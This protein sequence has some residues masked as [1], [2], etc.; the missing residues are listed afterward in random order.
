V[1]VGAPCNTCDPDARFANIQRMSKR[2]TLAGQPPFVKGHFPDPKET[3]EQHKSG[4]LTAR[5][6]AMLG[7][8]LL[9]SPKERQKR[10]IEGSGVRILIGWSAPGIVALSL[11]GTQRAQAASIIR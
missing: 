4:H 2:S 8:Q 1:P 6:M 5:C 7:E 11:P 10:L 3:F 9:V